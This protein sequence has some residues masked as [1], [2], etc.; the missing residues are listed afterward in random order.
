MPL[1]GLNIE[2]E[3]SYA[4]LH[5]V[6]SN[7][8]LNSRT[9]TRHEDNYT[10]D[11]QV[12]YFDSI[13]GSYRTDVS[14]RVQLKATTAT[15][16]ETS[17]HF[18]F[19]FRGIDQYDRLRDNRGEPHRILVVLFL[20]QNPQDWL[21]CSP[22]EL[23]L[24]KAAYWVS[25]YGAPSTTNETSVTVYIPKS[26]LLTEVSLR[27]ICQEIGRGNIPFYTVP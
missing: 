26:Q 12:D 22:T 27:T 17:T 2:S 3:L 24:K 1:S 21:N 16:A 6:A 9:G 13:S 8:G 19:P 15:V 14:L 4:Y 5:A 11:A 10:I 25:L 7:A 20:P 18:S 23:I